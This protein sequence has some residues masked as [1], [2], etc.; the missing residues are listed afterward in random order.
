[1]PTIPETG[2]SGNTIT[3][4]YSGGSGL[5]FPGEA[6]VSTGVT[7]LTATLEPGTFASGSGSVN[8]II[9]GT[10]NVSGLATFD[11]EV[12]GQTCSVKVPVGCGAYMAA[13]Q[14]KVFSC[15]NL[16]AANTSGQPFDLS[17]E[18]IGDYW[19]WGDKLPAPGGGPIS[20]TDG[21]EAA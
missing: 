10:A 21:N 17:W 4:N 15:F 3:I 11:L 19:Q 6:V 13:G 9:E 18:V 7:G 8:Y 1:M 2:A 16:G 14:W 20:A 5:P 12:G